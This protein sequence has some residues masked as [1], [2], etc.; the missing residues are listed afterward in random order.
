[1]FNEDGDSIVR[2]GIIFLVFLFA[3]ILVYFTISPFVEAMFDALDDVDDPETSDEMDTY[4]PYIRTAM[5]MAFAIG[6][7]TPVAWIFIWV[8]S[9]EPD[10]R[11]YRRR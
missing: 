9:R 4:L 1:L 8:F 5:T 6:I 3:M 10:E 11:R 7:A 2:A